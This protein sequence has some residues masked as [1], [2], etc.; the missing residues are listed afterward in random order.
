MTAL[1]NAP[2]LFAARPFEPDDVPCPEPD[3]LLSPELEEVLSPEL[4]EVLS[5]ELEEVLSPELEEVPSSELDEG[6]AASD[7]RHSAMP[8][9]PTTRSQIRMPPTGVELTSCKAPD[10]SACC[11]DWPK[12]AWT[13]IQPTSM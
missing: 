2:S 1:P 5:P 10:L 11:P 6:K 7:S 12:A 4:E 9:N 3:V 8:V 13:A